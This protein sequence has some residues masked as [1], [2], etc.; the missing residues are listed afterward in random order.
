MLFRTRKDPRHTELKVISKITTPVDGR[1]TK[2]EFAPP[3]LI[4]VSQLESKKKKRG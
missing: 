4:I 3:V 1:D 2:T